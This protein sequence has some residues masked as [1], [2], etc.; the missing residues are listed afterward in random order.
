M[1]EPM[2]STEELTRRCRDSLPDF[3]EPGPIKQAKSADGNFRFDTGFYFTTKFENLVFSI[4]KILDASLTIPVVWINFVCKES[5]IPKSRRIIETY[6]E[7]SGTDEI[8]EQGVKI[9][10]SLWWNEEN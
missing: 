8:Y 9:F 1:V 7:N 3:F 10:T 4:Y 2:F 5:G 6:F